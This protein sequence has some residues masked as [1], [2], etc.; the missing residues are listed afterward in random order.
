MW[1]DAIL[2]EVLFG[3]GNYSNM[4]NHSIFIQVTNAMPSFNLILETEKHHGK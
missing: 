2:N 1:V 3:E 4:K